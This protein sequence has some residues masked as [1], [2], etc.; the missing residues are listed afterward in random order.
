LWIAASLLLVWALAPIVWVA[1]SSISDRIELYAVPYKHWLPRNPTLQ[2][3]IELFTSGPKYRG[4]TVLP[5]RELL[6]SGLR[7]SVVLATGSATILTILGLLAG[8]TFSR[9]K[10]RGKQLLFI[11]LM[12]LVP[13]PVWVSLTSLYFMMSRVGLLDSLVGMILLFVAYGLPLYAWLMQ[14]YIDA[15][16]HEMEEAA[17]IDGCSRVR[18]LFTVVVPVVNPGLTSVFLVAF[19]TTWNNFLIPV[20]FAN[21][22]RAQPMTV[23]MALF[24]GQYEVVWESMSAAAMMIL[25]PPAILAL[26]FQRYLVRGLSIGAVG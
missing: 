11:L 21:S 19:L 2:N 18:A 6:I 12:A 20:I 25:L 4:G 16:P 8:Y 3:Y 1:I 14:T 24:I 9:L 7:N 26:F 5:A 23:V 22:M 15:V 17:L 10:I 13:L